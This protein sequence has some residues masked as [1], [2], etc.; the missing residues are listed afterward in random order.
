MVLLH[1]LHHFQQID[2]KAAGW[3][4]NAEFFRQM[5]VTAAIDHWLTPIVDIALEDKVRIVVHLIGET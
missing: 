1:I 4:G 2:P 5:V 3:T